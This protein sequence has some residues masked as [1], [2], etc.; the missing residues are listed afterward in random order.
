[1][2]ILTEMFEMNGN[3]YRTDTETLAV[4]REQVQAMRLEC[5]AIIMILG[6]ESGRIV[7]IGKKREVI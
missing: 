7:E 5:I 4:L 1:M 6:M 2:Y 3:I